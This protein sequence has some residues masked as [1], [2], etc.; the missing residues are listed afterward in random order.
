M[1]HSVIS[2][3]KHYFTAK[4]RGHDVHSPFAFQLCEEVFYNTNGFYDF[5]RLRKVREELL[6]DA[7]ELEIKDLGAGSKKLGARRKISE[8]VNSGTS[9]TKQSELLYR[10]INYLHPKNVI[11]LGTSVGLNTLYLALAD[12]AA[13]VYSMEGSENLSVYAKKLAQK[14]KIVNCEFICGNFDSQLPAL[15]MRVEKLDM[16]YVDGNHTYEATVRYFDLLLLRKHKDTV[17]IFDDIYWSEGMTKAWNEIKVHPDVTM[18]IDTFY[19]GMIFFK[20]EVKE[21]VGLRI[22]L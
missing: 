5:E 18:S 14:N 6:Q 21:R 11:E 17:L 3:I 20:E 7:T 1:M 22:K 15:L 10:L 13:K 12:K 8:I 2:Y 19:F 16:A 4:R 9:T